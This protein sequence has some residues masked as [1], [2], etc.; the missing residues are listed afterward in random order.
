MSRQTKAFDCV[1]M[2]DEAQRRLRA[3][4]EARKGEF[5]D[6]FAFVAAK[7]RESAHQREFWARLETAD[8]A[9]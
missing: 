6:Y 9:S 8:A 1:R 3:E 5:E 4:Y 7:S 2:K